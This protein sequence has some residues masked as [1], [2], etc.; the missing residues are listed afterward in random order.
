MPRKHTVGCNLYK[1]KNFFSLTNDA[2]CNTCDQF[3]QKINYSHALNPLSFWVTAPL[4]HVPL[5]E[6]W[7]FREKSD[8]RAFWTFCLHMHRK[9]QCTGFIFGML[10]A[11]CIWNAIKATKR[12]DFE[13]LY[14]FLFFYYTYYARGSI[15]HMLSNTWHTLT[16][17]VLLAKT[18]KK[19]S[20]QVKI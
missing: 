10:V 4:R 3:Q 2:L 5:P 9:N 6:S 18:W 11:C 7:V 12:A 17:K 8:G 19:F 20:R 13:D 16:Q 14:F 15:F 1:S